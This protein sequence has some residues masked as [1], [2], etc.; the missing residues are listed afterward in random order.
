VHRLR[1][2]LLDLDAQLNG[3][4][5]KREV[6]EKTQPTVSQRLSV[7]ERAVYRSL[8]GPTE[9][10]RRGLELARQSMESIQT[11][12]DRDLARLDEL[13]AALVA[14]GAPHVVGSGAK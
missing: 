6:G 8:Y 11:R 5:A 7:V 1:A 9:T 13:G 3:N 14:A 2:S 12:M 4:P 10:S